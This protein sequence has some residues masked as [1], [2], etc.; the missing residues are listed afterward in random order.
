MQ[1]ILINF[2]HRKFEMVIYMELSQASLNRLY[3]YPWFGFRREEERYTMPH[4][5][6]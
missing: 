2:I 5:S 4:D 1:T 6:V 3:G